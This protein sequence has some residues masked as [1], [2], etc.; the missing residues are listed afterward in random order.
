MN[1]IYSNKPLVVL[2]FDTST[3]E[4]EQRDC[5]IIDF[6]FCKHYKSHPSDTISAKVKVNEVISS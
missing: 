1:V 4:M 2:L 3:C 5:V 6:S